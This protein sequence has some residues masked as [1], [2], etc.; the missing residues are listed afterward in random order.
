MVAAAR[1]TRVL[2]LMASW[3]LV[4]ACGGAN[5]SSPGTHEASTTSLPLQEK[6]LAVGGDVQNRATDVVEAG[7]TQKQLDE[8]AQACR[9]NVG[10]VASRDNCADGFS[11]I[12]FLA[13]CG[14]PLP[15]CVHVHAFDPRDQKALGEHGYIE[16]TEED[17]RGPTCG[18]EAGGVCM[19]LGASTA[20][21]LDEVTH[22]TPPKTTTPPTTTS[23]P[24]T[25]TSTATDNPTTS[26]TPPTATSDQGGSPSSS[27]AHTTP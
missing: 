10:V 26:G 22:A 21:V 15:F 16:V 1:T 19:R 12:P 3:F 24:P 9:D 11:T 5:G 23:T 25:T 2:I 8:I 20:A 6:A 14:P 7:L 4:V 18:G 17:P 27:S 13:P